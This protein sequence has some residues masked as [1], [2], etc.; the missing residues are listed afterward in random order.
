MSGERLIRIDDIVSVVSEYYG[1]SQPDIL[2]SRGSRSFIRPRQV[3]MYLSRAL[4]RHSLPEI[5][6]AFDRDHTTVL[7]AV[8]KAEA[9]MQSDSEW[10][11]EVGLLSKKCTECVQSRRVA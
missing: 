9:M 2:S 8:R 5:G 10:K 1:V 6:R 11:T 7:Y 3:A 4:T